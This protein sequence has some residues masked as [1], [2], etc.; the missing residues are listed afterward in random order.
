L[1][2]LV[3]L[4]FWMSFVPTDADNAVANKAKHT[5]Q[6]INFFI[7]PGPLNTQ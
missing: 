1:G 7:N 2:L 3:V 6:T 4:A 5:M